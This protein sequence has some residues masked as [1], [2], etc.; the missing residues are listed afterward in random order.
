M[1]NSKSTKRA[2]VSSALAVFL[3]VAM[4]IGTTFAWFTDTASTSVNKIQAGT[5]D[6]ALEMYENGE[7]VSAEG[8]T[9]NFVKAAG[10]ESEA[11][12]WEPGCTYELPA[13]R[14]VNKGNLALKY[15][16]AISGI[17]GDAKLNDAIDWTY[18]PMFANGTFGEQGSPLSELSGTALYPEDKATDW[19]VAASAFKIIGHMKETA[20]NA[21]QGLSIDGIAITVYA[22]QFTYEHDSNGNDYDKNAT[23]PSVW[24]G[25]VGTVPAKD[26]KDGYRHITSAAQFA[27]LMDE[28]S[29]GLT[30][31]LY[32]GET[33][34]LDCDID[35]TDREITGIGSADDNI[36][37]TFDGNGH[38]ISNFKINSTAEYY[39]GLFNQFNGTVKN[40]TV[41]NA[42]V[43]GKAMVGAI[44]SN[45]EGNGATVENCKVYN[46]TIIGDKK[47]GAVVGYVDN[48]TVENCYAENCTVICGDSRNDQASETVGYIGNNC[49]VNNNTF[50]NVTVTRSATV[51][52][53][54]A[55]LKDALSKNNANTNIFLSDD[56]S[57]TSDYTPIDIG[58][59]SDYNN[60]TNLTINGNGHTISGLKSALVEKISGNCSLTISN[61]TVKGAAINNS[62]YTNGMGNGILVGYVE[63]GNVTLNNCHVADS[64]ITESSVATA[65]LIGYVSGNNQIKITDCTVK[66]TAVT[67]DSAAGFIG[68]VQQANITVSGCKVT[69]STFT[70]ETT[71][72][73]GA[74]FGTVNLG[75]IANVSNTTADTTALVGR[76]LS[77]GAVNYN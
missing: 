53:N 15:T 48:G 35:F 44:A 26:S 2:L 40:L 45:A 14:V 17:N 60:V 31:S 55:Q 3:C 42:N 47:V 36:V 38:T 8:K 20:G 21:Y 59:Y 29:K 27:A 63:N 74:Y 37:F 19:Q 76:I 64:S 30:N 73:Q 46:S 54:V 72:K 50:K 7:W 58:F 66:N 70:G 22:T 69:G 32:G 10:H 33:F 34:V 68:Y 52:A 23:L 9:L 16:I 49:T 65:A 41:K 51:V 39:A 61:L 18:V 57:V 24:N 11:I 1:T 25:D 5:L 12:L 75:T 56:I 62:S 4:L 43:T 13:L 28:T 67:G 71:N 6:V 77:T